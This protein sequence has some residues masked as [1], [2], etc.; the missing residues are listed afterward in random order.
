M[1]SMMAS[2]DATLPVPA[3]TRS[4]ARAFAQ[5]RRPKR[6]GVM[7]VARS[8]SSIFLSARLTS[9][10]AIRGAYDTPRVSTTLLTIVI[11]NGLTTV[12]RQCYIVGIGNEIL[13]P[14]L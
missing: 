12:K 11:T 5:A 9:F 13:R 8:Q 14:H 6:D 7:P 10:S 3:F 4:T 2:S 1:Y